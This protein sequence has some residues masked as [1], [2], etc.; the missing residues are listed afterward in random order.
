MNKINKTLKTMIYKIKIDKFLINK[1]GYIKI[2]ILHLFFYL[3]WL[4]FIYFMYW[5]FDW[6]EFGVFII[7]N[8]TL[9][10]LEK[11]RFFMIKMPIFY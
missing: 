5:I 3:Y 1:L 6:V 7:I 2:L 9:D 11:L 4:F 10:R 8:I